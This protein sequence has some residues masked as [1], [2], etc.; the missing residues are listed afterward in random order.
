MRNAFFAILISLATLPLVSAQAASPNLDDWA[1]IP[2]YHHGRIMPLDTFANR[3][4][5]IICN[6]DRGDV[7]LNLKPYLELDQSV[8]D[9]PYAAAEE[10]F[11]KDGGQRKWSSNEILLSW[12]SEPEKWEDAP[13]LY[14][15]HVDVREALG[16]P[17][18]GPTGLQLQ[19][20]T[21]RQIGESSEYLEYLQDFRARAMKA[22][23][24][25]EEIEP[26]Q[27]D[28]DIRKF[29]E[30]YT[31]FR[32]ISFDPQKPLSL[33]PLKMP[34]SRARFRKHL[35]DVEGIVMK[36]N[37][38]GKHFFELL[39]SIANAPGQEAL[40]SAI[41]DT[42][43]SLKLLLDTGTTLD[44][45]HHQR[46]QEGAVMG[47]VGGELEL[48]GVLDVVNDL[49]AASDELE[50]ATGTNKQRIFEAGPVDEELMNK[51]RP[52]FRQVHFQAAELKRLSFEMLISLYDD[53]DSLLVTPG[54]NVAALSPNRDTSDS[55][56]PW[57]SLTAVLHSD[58]LMAPYQ[59][60]LVEEV[61]DNW[62]S[63]STAY[64]NREAEDRDSK[65]A[66]AQ[67]KLATSLRKLGEDI[68]GDRSELV[69]K[70]LPLEEQ[71]AQLLA[72]TKYPS[73]ELIATEVK[74]NK[75]RPFMWSFVISLVGLICFAM[76]FGSLR[77]PMF[78]AGVAV[79]I[80]AIVWT[81]YGFKLRVTI[82]GW[83]PVTNMYE[84]VI[85]VPFI[86]A[87]LGVWFLLLPLTWPGLRDAA[88]LSA[89]P[90]SWEASELTDSQ[91]KKAPPE[92]WLV[93]NFLSTAFRLAGMIFVV[94]ILSLSKDYADGDRAVISLMP[95]EMTI[96]GMLT[97]SV[98]MV[99]LIASMWWLP[100]A[101]VIFVASLVFIPWN[102][103]QG[104]I[105]K[106]LQETYKR[107]PFGIAA[108]L[109]ASFFFA[110]ASFLPVF[111]EN[112]SPLQPVLRSNFWLTIHVL[113]IVAS[114]GAGALAWLLGTIALTYYLFA[115][116]R[117]P[118]V[119]ADVVKLMKA[120]PYEAAASKPTQQGGGARLLPDGTLALVEQPPIPPE[121]CIG[122]TNYAYRAIQVAVLLLAT[123]TILGGLWADVSW[124]R[125]WG[126]DPKE[127]WALISLLVY[128]AVL[129]GRFAGW[130]NNFGLAAGTV[131]GAT[132]IG[133]SWYGVNFILPYLA[134][135]N[136]GLHSYGTG[137]TGQKF[138]TGF[139]FFLVLNL[140]YL[141]IASIRYRI[142]M[143]KLV[144]PKISDEKLVADTLPEADSLLAAKGEAKKKKTLQ[145][146]GQLDD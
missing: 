127:V 76:S 27:L 15:P 41:N 5:D 32:S 135:G 18:E 68:E 69:E 10:L 28:K 145:K 139:F 36:P 125:F 104:D 8:A 74:Y 56:K 94:W 12:L 3:A 128:L 108:A 21:P 126:W 1:A 9:S 45:E 19:F 26:T 102:L 132:M 78:W 92:L 89:I 122:L 82:T 101:L 80:L 59:E 77:K 95:R 22:R 99:C 52:L 7:K 6:K 61:R 111:D 57:Y 34:G 16:L 42:I 37:A 107:A 51:M 110:M 113:T 11:G 143:S 123:G 103:L 48:Q 25:E 130:F 71:D 119:S 115:K 129:H 30:R 97:W 100:R 146:S 70:E 144:T 120:N 54:M 2:V 98:S 31:L 4:K 39:G 62:K 93:G 109:G 17:I 23:I 140:L 138:A 66:S 121:Q 85:F 106:G 35:Q 87:S 137:D 63:L 75:L 142:T 118:E 136:V 43:S 133:F 24:S 124:G 50:E 134:D 38:D 29:I 114:Y 141:A 84:T 117:R 105:Q 58:D 64:V 86:L 13:F 33:S 90:F 46:I 116:Y 72:Y 88:R 60:S 112:F 73:K 131:F 53:E 14:C 47:E 44:N 49:Y 83:A 79:T 91:R 67:S 96:N 40:G 55:A 20:A 81:I 65:I